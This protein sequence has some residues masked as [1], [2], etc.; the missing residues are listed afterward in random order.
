M[1]RGL[2]LGYGQTLITPTTE[3]PPWETD[4]VVLAAAQA[5]TAAQEEYDTAN[6]AWETA[7][8][9]LAERKILSAFDPRQDWISPDGKKDT[10]SRDKQL[11]AEIAARQQRDNV[12]AALTKARVAYQRALAKA[13]QA[14]LSAETDRAP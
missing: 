13:R 5:E 2:I 14:A 6:V 10:R 11:K 8:R 9:K 4:P 7:V 12:G 3:Q 1:Q